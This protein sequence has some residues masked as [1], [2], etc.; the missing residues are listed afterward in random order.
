MSGKKCFV[1]DACIYLAL[2]PT[3]VGHH[4]LHPQ[5]VRGVRQVRTRCG[6]GLAVDDIH[7]IVERADLRFQGCR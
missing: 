4:T 7:N 3:V 1:Q 5:S 6:L 2:G